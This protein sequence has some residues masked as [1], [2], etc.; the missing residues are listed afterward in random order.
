MKLLNN[1]NNREIEMSRNNESMGT[2][3]YN[4]QA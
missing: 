1:Y 4:K 3:L 2:F